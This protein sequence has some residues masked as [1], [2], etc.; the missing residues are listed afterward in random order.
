MAGI[1]GAGY[2]SRRFGA[3]PTDGTLATVAPE[4]TWTS[5]EYK[6]DPTEGTSRVKNVGNLYQCLVDGTSAPSG[7]GPTGTGDSIVDG[8]TIWQFLGVAPSTDSPAG[9]QIL[10][11]LV[12]RNQNSVDTVE[13]VDNDGGVYTSATSTP[14]VT[15]QGTFAA[16][17]ASTFYRTTAS[18]GKTDFAT[19][20]DWGA[21]GGGGDGDALADAWVALTGVQTGAPHA[22]SA[23]ETA[24][25]ANILTALP[26]TTTTTCLI[27]SYW[28]GVG[29]AGD[30]GTSHI[31]IPLNGLTLIPGATFLITTSSGF[32][33]QAAA[34][35]LASAGT[36]SEQWQTTGEGAVL[37]TVAFEVLP[38]IAGS[39]S[40]T[41]QATTLSS[42]GQVQIQGASAVSL[43]ATT[44]GASGEIPIFGSLSRALA[45]ATLVS[46]GEIPVTGSLTAS[47]L[48]ATLTS[49]G[50]VDITGSASPA[51]RPAS[52]SSSGAVQVSGS[53]SSSLQETTLSSAGTVVTASDEVVGQLAGTLRPTTLV[54]RGT[55]PVT[56]DSIEPAL[57]ELL[58][59]GP[60]EVHPRITGP[61]P[62]SIYQFFVIPLRFKNPAIIHIVESALVLTGQ[63]DRTDLANGLR[64]YRVQFH[65]LYRIDNDRN[66]PFIFLP[67]GAKGASMKIRFM[68][69]DPTIGQA[70]ATE[71]KGIT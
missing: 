28:F 42:Q 12:R 29:G 32:I 15:L 17:F 69:D 44:L 51:L 4:P 1:G 3:S 26:I 60:Y 65:S 63:A 30:P 7:S 5:T 45:A 19:F 64:V 24:A 61:L 27:V 23:L 46:T 36:F 66:G 18:N 11:S 14:C 49:S 56:L 33:Q 9:S 2:Q 16:P 25:V 22:T 6:L 10:V 71:W 39:L 68:V 40:A 54:S 47:L 52:L 21:S 31:A 70:L 55:V 62:R 50:Q 67:V 48:S 37:A 59:G 41:L 58:G 53:L 20:A 8:S 13:P 57:L 43:R 35:R 34:F 38:D